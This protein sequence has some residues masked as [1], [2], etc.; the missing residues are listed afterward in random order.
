MDIIFEDDDLVYVGAY[1]PWKG[2]FKTKREWIADFH[3][4][5]QDDSLPADWLYMSQWSWKPGT[6]TKH[7]EN[8]LH[9]RSLVLESDTLGQDV[10]PIYKWLSQILKLY[11]IVYTGAKS[12]HGWFAAPTKK[13]EAELEEI[14]EALQLDKSMFSKALTRRPGCIRPETGWNQELAYLAGRGQA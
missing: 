5:T 6:T 4:P 3:K 7:S 12:Y 1:E 10:F 8:K 14:S 13:Q 11:A 2:R 9:R